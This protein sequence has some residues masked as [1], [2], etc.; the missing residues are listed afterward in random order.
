MARHTSIPETVAIS[1]LLAEHGNMKDG[2]YHYHPEWSDERV[3]KAVHPDLRMIHA[4]TIRKQ[5][6]GKLFEKPNSKA[7]VK[8][9]QL[10]LAD[11]GQTLAQL[12][13]DW[14]ELKH[15]LDALADLHAKLCESLSV[16]RVCDVRHLAGKSTLRVAG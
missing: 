14:A 9:L 12:S 4:A 5:V 7:D 10:G 1:K 2:Y 6:Y 16:N 8:E 13:T 15:R 11:M 3:A